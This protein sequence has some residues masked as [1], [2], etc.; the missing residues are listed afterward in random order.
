MKALQ[1]LFLLY[2]Y[3]YFCGPEKLKHSPALE[4]ILVV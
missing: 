3:F 4:T 2:F 1:E